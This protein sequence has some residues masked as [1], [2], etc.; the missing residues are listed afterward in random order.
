MAN[1][2]IPLNKENERIEVVKLCVM[3]REKATHIAVEV[4]NLELDRHT[5]TPH[6][7]TQ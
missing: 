5:N 2:Y 6:I 3:I 7:H 4:Q 1:M